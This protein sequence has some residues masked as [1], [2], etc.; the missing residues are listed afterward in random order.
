VAKA[1]TRTS[2]TT[3]RQYAEPLSWSARWSTRRRSTTLRTKT[4]SVRSSKIRSRCSAQSSENSYLTQS[5]S[6]SSSILLLLIQDFVYTTVDMASKYG[7]VAAKIKAIVAN[8][9]SSM[10]GQAPM[11]CNAVTSVAGRMAETWC[12]DAGYKGEELDGE[13]RAIG[14]HTQCY[15]CSGWDHTSSVCLSNGK[16][17][18]KGKGDDRKGGKNKGKGYSSKPFVQDKGLGKGS[19]TGFKGACRHYGLT[20]HRPQS[21]QSYQA[22]VVEQASAGHRGSKRACAL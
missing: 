5:G 15:R 7:D 10:Q 3:L 18:G 1:G 9:V 12:S 4:W 14:S 11:D 17:K 2:R 20:G 13:I 22:N 16:G 19:G 6:A 8:K 21:S